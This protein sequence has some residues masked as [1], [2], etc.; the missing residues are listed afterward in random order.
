MLSTKAKIGIARMLSRAI[1]AWRATLGLS[2][3]VTARRGGIV[4]QLD[5]REGIDLAIFLGL[6]QRI[7]QRVASQWIKPDSV[8]LDIGANIGAHSLPLAS[9]IGPRG[10]VICIEPTDYAFGK[11]KANAAL[12]PSL[13]ERM[14][15]LQAALT[16][17][18]TQA[19][20]TPPGFYS[21]WPLAGEAEGRHARHLGQLETAEAARFVALDELFDELVASGRAGGQLS[22]VKLDV[23]GHEVAVL[24]GAETTLTRYRPAMV[25]EIAPHVQ[26]EV[27]QRF[28]QLI[29]TL[30]AYGYRLEE[31]AGRP[32]PLSA[33]ALRG[34]I[35]DGGSIDAVALPN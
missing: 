23:D 11:L 24:R 8:V 5:L 4:W 9:R 13:G 18:S 7:P 6:Y 3:Q 35:K 28:E 17:K 30:Q 20:E 16:D 1:M 32:L 14:V 15:L 33:P 25:L 2:P 12:N 10:Q 22:L 29:E 21:R 19:R 34:L 27:P 31:S 26:D